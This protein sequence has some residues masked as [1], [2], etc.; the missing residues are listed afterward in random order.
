M[1]LQYGHQLAYF[2][3]SLQPLFTDFNRDS[4]PQCCEAY[5]C[6]MEQK[7]VSIWV[8]KESVTMPPACM[9]RPQYCN[10]AEQL[11]AR[12][13]MVSRPSAFWGQKMHLQGSSI[14]N[15]VLLLQHTGIVLKYCKQ[16]SVIVRS[17]PEARGFVALCWACYWGY[18]HGLLLPLLIST[19]L[20]RKGPWWLGHYEDRDLT[21]PSPEK[22]KQAKW[23]FH[24]FLCSCSY[25]HTA[26]THGPYAPSLLPW[27]IT[28]Q[29][30]ALSTLQRTMTAFVGQLLYLSTSFSLALHHLSSAGHRAQPDTSAPGLQSP[31]TVAKELGILSHSG[32]AVPQGLLCLLANSNFAYAAKRTS[33]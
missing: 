5:L 29:V 24:L 33:W 26:S 10:E 21:V 13:L 18:W 8:I 23:L 20:R 25:G 17:T 4:S 12:P 1:S 9:H 31:V 16:E 30:A 28:L 2:F 6:I 32:T 15:T 7:P 11:L 3:Y 22:A 19:A 27:R 14:Q